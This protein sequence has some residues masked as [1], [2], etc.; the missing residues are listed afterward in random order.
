MNVF[1]TARALWERVVRARWIVYVRYLVVAWIATLACHGALN[2]LP[3]P[4]KW[5]LVELP[6]VR[7]LEARYFPCQFIS[8]YGWGGGLCRVWCWPSHDESSWPMNRLDLYESY[9]LHEE[10]RGVSEIRLGNAFAVPPGLV[11]T[12][13]AVYRAS[14]RRLTA[15]GS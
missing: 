11:L 4:W 3:I 5:A 6:V 10:K 13:L 1:S 15:A 14:R 7:D 12:A 8:N 9:Y 2:V